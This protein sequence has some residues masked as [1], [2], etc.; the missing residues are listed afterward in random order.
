MLE[1]GKPTPELTWYKNNVEMYEDDNPNTSISYSR[2]RAMLR[3]VKTNENDSGCY[4]CT[5]VNDAGSTMSKA[6]LQVTPTT[7][8]LALPCFTRPLSS[9]SI[10]E[11]KSAVFSA[12]LEG[13][14]A[15]DSSE[16]A[17][18][19]SVD[20]SLSVCS[21]DDS[22]LLLIFSQT[23]TGGEMVQRWCGNSTKCWQN[24]R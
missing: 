24:S 21:S 10:D 7:A 17:A 8:I 4:K 18:K 3:L 14:Y 22:F 13:S 1:T 11:G 12:S 19:Y 16:A 20:L 23:R 5:A 15:S 2:G 6:N 9:I